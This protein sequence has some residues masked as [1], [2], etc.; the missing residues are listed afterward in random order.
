MS[1]FFL[2]HPFETS[3]RLT[4]MHGWH[5]FRLFGCMRAC[6]C[7]ACIRCLNSYLCHHLHLE[8]LPT[9]KFR[10]AHLTDSG[11]SLVRKPQL[12]RDASG[13][14]AEALQVGVFGPLNTQPQAKLE[15]RDDS[16]AVSS[17]LE[18]S[19]KR[20]PQQLPN[21]SPA[22]RPRLSNG[23]VDAAASAPAATGDTT[24]TSTNAAN[25]NTTASA[26]T[27]M[28]VDH[29]HHLP[30]THDSN[31]D[32]SSNH[33]YPSPLEGEQQIPPPILRTDG[34]EQ[35][36]QVDKVEELSPST[37]FIRLMD[38]DRTA[39]EGTTTPSPSP[40]GADNA[41]VLLQCE[42]N[43][44]DPSIL[45]AA[46]TDALARIWTVSRATA[47]DPSQ[48]HVSPRAHT[49]LDPETPRT[50]TVTALSWTSD[51]T[52]IALATDSGSLATVSV[53]SAEGAHLQ[54]MEVSEPPVIKLNWN[55]SNTALLAIS[56][57][58]RWC[59]YNCIFIRYRERRHLQPA[60]TRHI[61]HSAGCCLDKRR[62]VSAGRGRLVVVPPLHRIVNCPGSEIRDQRR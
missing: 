26:T 45:A 1:C 36:T 53:W 61:Q 6:V 51:G 16:V 55:P 4:S 29:S 56:P 43:P 20:I 25:P 32:N 34:P 9:A 12:P 42:W 41:P 50:T 5:P 60:R 28:D 37:T 2:S 30:Q 21:G 52:A 57:G 27:P 19:R 11:S 8:S 33:A 62:R 39:L 13:P 14:E 35:G 7:L 47:P 31:Q 10:K 24:T 17:E 46:G 3:P 49:L 59:S 44:S 22:K 15:E 48:D 54:T 18:S 23:Y 40:V 58:Q 38:D